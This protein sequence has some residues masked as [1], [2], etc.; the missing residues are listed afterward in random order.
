MKKIIALITAAMVAALGLTGCMTLSNLPLSGDTYADG[1]RYTGGDRDISDP[2]KN[3]DLDWAAGKVFVKAYEGE[4]I[5]IRETV[6]RDIPEDARVHSYVDGTTLR[7][8]YCR[9]G[10][11]GSF[12]FGLSKELTVCV[13]ADMDLDSVKIDNASGALEC[14]GIN[15]EKLIVD[16]AS[17]GVKIESLSPDVSIDHASGSLEL[18]QNAPIGNCTVDSASGSV[19]LDFAYVPEKLSL[20][21]ASGG[22]TICLPEDAGFRLRLDQASG[23]FDCE[24]PVHQYDDTYICGDESADFDIDISSGGLHLLAR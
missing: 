6:N 5:E 20:D 2:V 8:R 7:I 15:S 21:S 16:T 23:G 1:D 22:V 9:S 3:I 17:G 24:L 4:C 19:K 13:P 11:R 14:T 10:Y 12:N 18:V